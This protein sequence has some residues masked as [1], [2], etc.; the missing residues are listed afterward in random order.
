MSRRLVYLTFNPIRIKRSEW[1]SRR[2]KTPAHS[3]KSLAHG[4]KGWCKS[5]QPVVRHSPTQQQARMQLNTRKIQEFQRRS[6]QQRPNTILILQQRIPLRRPC[7]IKNVDSE[8]P[9][10]TNRTYHHSLSTLL[11]TETP[12]PRE[13]HPP[14]PAPQA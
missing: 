10:G 5:S 1:S 14:A 4:S 11:L 12:G 3:D 8:L 7:T 2:P 9:T 13:T 6:N